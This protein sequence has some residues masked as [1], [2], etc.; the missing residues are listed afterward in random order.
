MV[1]EQ[2]EVIWESPKNCL[3]SWGRE[4]ERWVLF[5]SS[6]T[7]FVWTHSIVRRPTNNKQHIWI[8]ADVGSCSQLL[9]NHYLHFHKMFT[10]SCWHEQSWN[11]KPETLKPSKSSLKGISLIFKKNVKSLALISFNFFPVS[12]RHFHAIHHFWYC[13]IMQVMSESFP[14]FSNR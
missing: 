6:H 1:F 2:H 13:N 8:K 12:T 10:L 3:T 5:M 14:Y 4:R 9:C 11:M 7:V